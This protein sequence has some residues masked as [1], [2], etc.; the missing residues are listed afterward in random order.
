MRNRLLAQICLVILVAGFTAAVQAEP[1][2]SVT[3]DAVGPIGCTDPVTYTVNYDPNGYEAGGAPL[4]LFGFDIVMENDDLDVV[5]FE[6]SDVAN[7]DWPGLFLNVDVGEQVKVS[8]TFLSAERVTEATDLFSIVVHGNSTSGIGELNIVDVTLTRDVGQLNPQIIPAE[9]WATPIATIAVD[10]TPPDAPIFF[11]EPEF[12]PGTVNTVYWNALVDAAEYNVVCSNGEVSGWQAATEFTFGNLMHNITYTYEVQA[13]DALGNEGVFSASVISTQDAVT[14]ESAVG[15]LDPAYG[16]VLFDVPWTASDDMSGVAYV[17]LRYRLVG[18][19][20]D[21]FELTHTVSPIAFEAD[22][23]DGLYEFYTIATDNAGNVEVDPEIGTV[24]VNVDTTEPIAP[25]IIAEPDFTPGT[26]NTIYW[27]PVEGATLYLVSCSNGT[28]SGWIAGLEWTFSDLIDGTTYEYRVRAKDA[29]ENLG[30]FSDPAESSTQDD[31]AP[32]SDID[33]PAPGNIAVQAFDIEVVLDDFGGSGVVLT[34][35]FYNM[36]GTTWIQ[37]GDGFPGLIIPFVAPDDGVFEF[38]TIAE[39]AVGNV[40]DAP[41]EPLL[42]LTVDTY[43]PIGTFAINDGAEYTT[44]C[45]VILNNDYDDINDVVSMRFRDQ[46]VDP[47]EVWTEGWIAYVDSFLWTLDCVGEDYIIQAQ[48]KDGTDQITNAS[49]SIILDNTPPSAVTLPWNVGLVSG[50]N[51]ITINWIENEVDTDLEKVEIWAALWDTLANDVGVSAYPEYDDIFGAPTTPSPVS[52]DSLMVDPDYI[53]LAEVPAGELTFL[54][55][56]SARGAYFYYLFAKDH[57]GNYSAPQTTYPARTVNYILGDFDEDGEIGIITDVSLFASAYGTREVAGVPEAGYDG[58]YDIGLYNDPWFQPIPVTDNEIEFNDLMVLASNF[59]AQ[60]GGKSSTGTPET[61]VL[62][63]YQLDDLNWA[64]G[65]VEPCNSLKGLRVSHLLPENATIEYNLSQNLKSTPTYFLAN[66]ERNGLD[67]GFA[68]LGNNSVFPG[69]GEILKV[70]TSEPMDLTNV[71]IQVRDANNESIKFELKSE[72][73]VTLPSVY[74]LNANYPNPFNPQTTIKFALPEAQDVRL[75]IFNIKG[76]RVRVLMS[77]S[78]SA[79]V[80][81][82]I[83]NG[84]DGGGRTV[85]SGTYFYRLQAGPMNETQRML[86]LK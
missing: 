41:D 81:S 45:D 4:E 23:G 31:L 6:A 52:L 43:G 60:S 51:S 55:E 32:D 64:L 46:P 3:T 1:I 9:P 42:T 26:T 22:L 76:Q 83:W 70:T 72:P 18:G 30:D 47:E 29:L 2:I 67:L 58:V 37:F 86:L 40:E 68:V 61:P 12:T 11:A 69:S 25:T 38:Y 15:V 74:S 14:P 7:I 19:A 73:L 62:T 20:W 48:F 66:N 78:M 63:W 17:Q 8:G 50:N 28:D 79:G 75:E 35:L 49:D 5:T 21:D 44:S 24:Q 71:T 80:H 34:R 36:D 16:T 53:L 82:V 59:N 54:H 33:A 56:A 84:T 85:A 27:D 39:D 65:L 10:C 57:A 77:E 13:R